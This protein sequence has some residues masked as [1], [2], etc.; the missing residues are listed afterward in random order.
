M[1]RLVL[2]G[3][4]G[5]LMLGGCTTTSAMTSPQ[6]PSFMPIGAPV[7]GPKGYADMCASMRRSL[8]ATQ[9]SSIAHHSR[10]YAT[11][12]ASYVQPA[13]AG[14][15]QAQNQTQAQTQARPIDTGAARLTLAAVQTPAPSEPVAASDAAR[16]DAAAPTSAILPGSTRAFALPSPEPAKTAAN[17]AEDAW[18]LARRLAQLQ[19]VNRNVNDH[20]I[21]RTDLA[22]Y[23]VEEFWTRSGAGRDSAGDCEDM[24]IEKRWELIEQGYPTED[25]FYAVAYRHGM[26]LHVVLVAHTEVG[27][28]IL[29]S[30]AP[31]ITTWD[32]AP[33]SWVKRQL[34]GDEQRWALIDTLP[35]NAAPRD[36]LIVAALDAPKE[37]QAANTGA[38][39]TDVAIGGPSH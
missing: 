30:R 8:C 31:N 3:V 37:A 1:R 11:Q 15:A 17:E 7:D 21:Q 28:L 33:Y 19:A 36:H 10:A 25:L 16:F 26:G 27:D 5:M 6:P 23:G 34:P 20:V 39:S 38:T 18:P 2:L 4:G 32:R 14:Q 9:T 29:D 12:L 35:A 13:P 22:N 24:A